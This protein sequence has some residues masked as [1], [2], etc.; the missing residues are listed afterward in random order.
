VPGAA[1]WRLGHHGDAEFDRVVIRDSLVLPSRGGVSLFPAAANFTSTQAVNASLSMPQGVTLRYTLD[2][3]EVTPSSMIWPGAAGAPAPLVLDG[4]CM[5]R[6]RGFDAQGRMTEEARGIYIFDAPQSGMVVL[7]QTGTTHGKWRETLVFAA[8]AT[9]A[10]TVWISVSGYI[11]PNLGGAAD[12]YSSSGAAIRVG[13]GTLSTG[14]LETH[15]RGPSGCSLYIDAE[16]G[17]SIT[18]SA[19]STASGLQDSPASDITISW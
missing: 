9:P 1:G 5:L 12:R 4:T 11:N 6:A 3:A 2:G 8:C 10:S 7:S 17:S 14:W 13:N 18:V 19:R 16:R 15:P